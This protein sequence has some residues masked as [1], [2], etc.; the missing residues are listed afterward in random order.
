MRA[1]PISVL[2]M[3]MGNTGVLGAW[4]AMVL[5]KIMNSDSNNE[6]SATASGVVQAPREGTD[7]TTNKLQEI[8]R[9]NDIGA[10][11]QSANSKATNTQPIEHKTQGKSAAKLQKSLYNFIQ[12]Q[13]LCL[14]R[15][16]QMENA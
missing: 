16:P 8:G 3:E 9:T 10:S 15:I 12:G 6:S 1:L 5:K 7:G 2:K 14:L 13:V 11:G 4:S